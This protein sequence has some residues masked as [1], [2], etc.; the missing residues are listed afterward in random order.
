MTIRVHA[1]MIF[2]YRVFAAWLLS[3]SND[4]TGIA[5]SLSILIDP[6][7]AV[8]AHDRVTL[9]YEDAGV[10]SHQAAAPN[11]FLQ[12]VSRAIERSN[13]LRETQ[14]GRN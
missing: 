10:P 8:L 9:T 12:E 7:N 4:Q 14:G 2:G 5:C 3:R 6:S 13:W 1:R 11:D